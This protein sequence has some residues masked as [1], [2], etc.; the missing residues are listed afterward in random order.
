MVWAVPT[1]V[2]AT[3]VASFFGFLTAVAE[4]MVAMSYSTASQPHFNFSTDVIGLLRSIV[5][6]VLEELPRCC[7]V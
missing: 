6:L 2:M 1:P 7:R 5:E 4:G 3:T